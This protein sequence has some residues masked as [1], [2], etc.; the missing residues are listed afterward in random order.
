MYEYMIEYSYYLN[1]KRVKEKDIFFGDNT[2][3]AVDTCRA[4]NNYYFSE[5]FG[6]I[7]RVLKEC[8]NGWEERDN[9][10]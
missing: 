8:Y 6:R 3:E 1:G 9:W 10:E 5:G 7:E 2:Q 4:E